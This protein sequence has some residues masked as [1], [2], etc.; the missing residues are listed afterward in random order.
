MQFIFCNENTCRHNGNG[1]CSKPELHI[2][3]KQA[4]VE[5]GK[6]L[7]YNVCR[8]YTEKGK[9]NAGTY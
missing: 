8:D 5:Q 3:T 2:Y 7:I 9:K 1:V 4:G 6:A